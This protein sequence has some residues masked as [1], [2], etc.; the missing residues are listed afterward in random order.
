MQK[1]YA[2]LMLLC[3]LFTIKVYAMESTTNKIKFVSPENEMINAIENCN[4]DH[5]K[6]NAQNCELHLGK[7]ANAAFH[8]TCPLEAFKKLTDIFGLRAVTQAH[9]ST[10]PTRPITERFEQ[11]QIVRYIHNH[12]ASK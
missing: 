5:I 8:S 12:A 1:N 4:L 7:F 3:S 9:N 6:L 10:F 2:L 11:P